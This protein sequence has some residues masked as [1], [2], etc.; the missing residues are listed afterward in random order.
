MSR[1]KSVDNLDEKYIDF[2][3]T[4][5]KQAS[6]KAF[7]RVFDN[8]ISHD[9]ITRMLNN[10]DTFSSAELWKAVKP[11]CR[12]VAYKDNI[13]AFDDTLIE[14][15]DT[16]ENEVVMYHYDHSKGRSVKGICMVTAL[17]HAG[18]MSI[19]VCVDI[20]KRADKD[21]KDSKMDIFRNL[22]QQCINNMLLFRH[23]LADTWYG[24]TE[25]MRYITDHCE[26]DFIFP[27][28]TNRQI[29]LL[30]STSY[31]AIA[32]LELEAG[33]VYEAMVKGYEKPLYI[34]HYEIKDDHD[35]P[36]G[37]YLVT[38]DEKLDWD[39]LLTCYQR[40]WQ[41]ELFHR[42]VKQ[43]AAI[44][45]APLHASKALISHCYASIRGFLKLEL[46]RIRQALSHDSIKALITYVSNQAS[47]ETLQK[48]ST[49]QDLA[50]KQL[51]LFA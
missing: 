18:I 3:L 20:V 6:G 5:N 28:K 16:K 42:S 25:N 38:S 35:N 11:L 2:L 32:D 29:K 37:L 15:P 17:Y 39:S 31:H 40:R 22:L 26:K 19:P 7:S 12:E 51:N 50:Y 33:K 30:G 41:V 47:Y 13:I 36:S 14:K 45:K 24:S 27:L 34:A 8:R 23:V 44:G 1:P 43:N 10:T 21:N 49:I 9:Q 48:L 46:L 4:T